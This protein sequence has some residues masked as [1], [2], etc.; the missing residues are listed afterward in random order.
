MLSR[1]EVLIR[2]FHIYT[3]SVSGDLYNKQLYGAALKGYNAKRIMRGVSWVWVG[4][5]STGSTLYI[6]YWDEEVA[7]KKGRAR[8]LR[9]PKNGGSQIIQN[10]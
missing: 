7:Y 10:G 9:D 2:T 6:Q 5:R 8:D 3:S 4:N 1:A